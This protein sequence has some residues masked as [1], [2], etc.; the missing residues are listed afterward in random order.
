M[1][2]S[3]PMDVPFPSLR[4][5]LVSLF[6]QETA[7]RPRYHGTGSMDLESAFGSYRTIGVGPESDGFWI[8]DASGPATAR[9]AR[10]S[11]ASSAACFSARCPPGGSGCNLAQG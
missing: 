8:T 11:T 5:E 2:G 7:M 9:C 4:S 10:R 3:I 1:Q 6:S